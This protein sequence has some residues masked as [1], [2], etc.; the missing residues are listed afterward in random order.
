MRPMTPPD[1][2]IRLD[3]DEARAPR[4][5]KRPLLMTLAALA[6]GIVGMAAWVWWSQQRA[7]SVAMAPPAP[8]E[9]AAP[10]AP[11]DPD[12]D[13][14]HRPPDAEGLPPLAAQDVPS[15]ITQ[16]L[17]RGGAPD[18]VQT[19][20]F[21]GRFAATVDNLARAHAP[22]LKWPVQPAPGRFLVEDAP[23]GG[24]VIAA[25]N[26]QRYAAFVAAATAVDSAAAAQLYARMYPL[27]QQSYRRLGFP[28]RA[29]HDRLVTVIDRLLATPEPGGPVA[30][31]LTEVKGPLASTRPWTRYEFA[32]PALEQLSAGQKMLVRMG[33]EHARRLK[34]K[35]R[36]VRGHLVPAATR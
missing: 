17:A 30:V 36:E 28:D 16:L 23:G 14:H 22:P 29:F 20:D 33:P 7:P 24:Q 27:L 13:G 31:Q 3:P 26:A 5:R 35:L 9:A 1:P 10:R 11:A 6:V 12:I 25:A 4:A 32:D 2:E 18:W 21:V 8:P 19:D 15:A 34:Q